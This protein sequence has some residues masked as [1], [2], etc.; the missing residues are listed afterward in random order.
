ME[1]R[2]VPRIVTYN[3]H[4]C[5]GTD[6]RHAPE[7]IA[8][9]LAALEPDI[10]ALQELDVGRARSGGVHQAELIAQRLG[11]SMLFH[12]A[13]TVLEE[14][15]GDAI[16]STLPCR[17]VRAS[18]LPGPARGLF[19]EPR[20]ALWAE[21]SVAGRPLQVI[22]T[23]LG[24]LGAERLLQSHALLGPDWLGHPDCQPPLILAGDF[25]APSASATFRR[26]RRHLHEA[27]GSQPGRRLP[28]F[29]SRM[30]IMALDHLFYRGPVAVERVS[31]VRTKLTRLAS[32]HLPLVMDFQVGDLPDPA[33]ADHPTASGAAPV[34]SG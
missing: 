1:S 30:P 27:Q 19:L 11:M 14:Q 23:H 32:D 16:L 24:L 2:A 22:N 31:V 21:I 4:S 33:E 29:P 18:P 3:V 15:Y 26:L 10:V 25:N 12:P 28:T 13:V 20:G 34:L 7:R 6:R 8:E 5:I 17:L 9:V